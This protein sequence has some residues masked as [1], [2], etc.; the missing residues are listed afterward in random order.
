MPFLLATARLISLL[1]PAAAPW[2]SALRM[3]IVVATSISFA[4]TARAA[5]VDDTWLKGAFLLPERLATQIGS[6][7]TRI[8]R[9]DLFKDGLATLKTEEKTPI[10]IVLH[11]CSGI[12]PEQ[13]AMARQL[14]DLGFSVFIP[15]HQARSN[16]RTLCAAGSD[17]SPFFASFDS[18]MLRHRREEFANALSEARKLGFTDPSKVLAAGH[19]QGA[20]AVGHLDRTDVTAAIITGWG[21][22]SPWWSQSPRSVPQ[23]AIRFRDDP[24][25]RPGTACEAGLSSGRDA[26]NT[27]SL[28]LDGERSHSVMHNENAVAAIQAFAKQYFFQRP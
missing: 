21:C 1:F 25:L 9:I 2:R 28:V 16:G 15:S 3:A 23:L 18:T 27:F 26:S 17:G 22:E 24:W 14:A 5:D 10:A 20:L 4:P 7:R 11:G 12:I 8:A 19:S 13:A 6:P